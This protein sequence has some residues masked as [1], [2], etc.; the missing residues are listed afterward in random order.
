VA[1]VGR[2]SMT[3]QAAAEVRQDEGQN[4]SVEETGRGCSSLRSI[5][6]HQ[7]LR[8]PPM[9][10]L[11]AHA[12]AREV[13]DEMGAL[14]VVGVHQPAQGQTKWQ[15]VERA[16]VSQGQPFSLISISITHNRYQNRDIVLTC[17]IR[18]CWFQLWHPA[19]KEPAKLRSATSTSSCR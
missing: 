19:C 2:S 6:M 5:R 10:R 16:G 8:R 1:Q 4:V 7:S 14:E 12:G 3:S 11:G 17:C 13:G 9:A 18:S 15:N